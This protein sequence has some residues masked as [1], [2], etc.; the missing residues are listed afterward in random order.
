MNINNFTASNKRL[1]SYLTHVQD[2]RSGDDS[3][4]IIGRNPEPQPQP[5]LISVDLRTYNW[6]IL[7][8]VWPVTRV[9]KGGS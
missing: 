8:V 5:V 4:G 2:L 9:G 6:Q 7:A 3:K 1:R